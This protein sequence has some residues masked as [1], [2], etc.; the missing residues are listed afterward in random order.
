MMVPSETES[1]MDG[2]ATRISSFKTELVCTPRWSSQGHIG[3]DSDLFGALQ[4][5]EAIS[6]HASEYYPQRYRYV[7]RED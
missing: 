2:T 5:Q 4:R 1:P 6:A 7:A 3:L